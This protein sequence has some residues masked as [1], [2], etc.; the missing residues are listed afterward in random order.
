MKKILILGANNSQVQLIRA[1][2][3]EGY[4]VVVCDYANDNPGLPFVDKHYQISYLDTEEVLSIARQEQIDGVIGNTDPA[5]PVVAYIA[6]QL[7]LVGNTQESI[8]KLIS[9]AA[10]RQ[11]QEQAGLYCPKH[12]ESDDC[13]I[14]E[15]QLEKLDYPIIV[16]PNECSGSQGTTKIFK[17]QQERFRDAF[18]AC[19]EIS[20]DG[21]VTV[22]EYVE[23][24]SLE[25]IEGDVFVLGDE[26]LWNGLFNIRR[27][28][29][30]P[31]LP[32]TKIFPVICTPDELS[33]I[34]R[35]VPKAFKEAGVRHGEYN[36]ELYF[37]A[38]R[39]LFII[40][41]NPR[42]GGNRIPQLI[43]RHTG[44]DFNR[45][46]VTTAVGDNSYYT[47]VRDMSPKINYLSQHI[48]FSNFSGVLDKI[49]IK[50]PV[51]Q[52]VIDVEFAKE[53]G[54]TVTQRNN[55]TDCIAY[56]TLQFPDRDTQL[57][58]SREQIEQLIYP[59]VKDKEMPIADGTLPYQ[60]IY[61][62]MTGDAYDFFV[63]KLEK[64]HRTAA[65]YAE[66]FSVYGTI[67]YDID[68]KNQLKGMVAGYTHNLR[69]P[70]RSLIA[71]VYVN[72]EHRGNGLGE[73]LL[74]R[75]ISHCKSLGMEGVWLH[76]REENHPARRLYQKLGFVYDE[77][78][79]EDGLLK[80]DL[81][82]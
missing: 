42:Q 49:E 74:S 11:I 28:V 70:R 8:N 7:G 58:Y 37:T 41:I 39:E 27:S 12:I 9:K 2:K 3:A 69:I 21:M 47:A 44:I 61:D 25:M 66:Q 79:N 34:K 53:V 64:V 20:H 52:Y 51:R 31:M 45:L 36:I 24:P 17:N 33:V 57:A 55:A 65:D 14:A 23:T 50:P 38:D 5:M 29:M 6:E 18:Q 80:M 60:V 1:A 77:S 75:Y 62:F 78:Y 16:K 67:A 54:R 59:V 35:D 63:P 15:A 26:I 4:Y 48:V 22:E 68:E 13:S 76:V 71:E 56:V 72:R 82:F 81:S 10:F 43:E 19:K 73:K 40:E 30:A 46:L 32:M